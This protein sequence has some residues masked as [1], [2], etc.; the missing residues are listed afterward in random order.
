MLHCTHLG[1][2]SFKT[3]ERVRSQRQRFQWLNAWGAYTSEAGS[4]SD[5][6]PC[7]VGRGQDV[8]LRGGEG[9]GRL[10]VIGGITSGGLIGYQGNQQRGRP[11]TA[12]LIRA[13]TSWGPGQVHR[14]SDLCIGSRGSRHWS[15]RGC[16]ESKR[17]AVPSGLTRHPG[18]TLLRRSFRES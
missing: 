6:P 8:A 9:K 13:V 2:P 3:E 14:R 10:P 7:V 4:W 15:G 17:T 1:L 5:T 16:T 11:L 12:P 18:R